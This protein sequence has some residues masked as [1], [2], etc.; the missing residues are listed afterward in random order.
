MFPL[1]IQNEV[2]RFRDIKRDDLP[3]IL[4]WYNK[5]EEYKYATGID[6]EISLQ[7][8]TRK[9]AEVAINS[10]EFFV[11][12][13]TA[14]NDCMVGILK[15]SVGYKSSDAIWISSIV[16]DTNF[17]NIGYGSRAVNLL[18]N[19][20]NINHKYKSIYISVVE[21]NVQGRAFWNKL[22]FK[23]MRVMENHLKLNDKPQ[24][25]IIMYKQL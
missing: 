17:Q 20:L 10:H 22:D 11:G 9:Y 5:I 15:G 3:L 25:V 18:I 21:E 1:N 19:H 13:Y 16:I 12:I 23:E 4:K 6:S 24:N 8:M 7:E 2:L 14:A